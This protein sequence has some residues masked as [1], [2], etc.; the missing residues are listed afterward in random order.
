MIDIDFQVKEVKLLP[1]LGE[2]VSWVFVKQTDGTLKT[3]PVIKHEGDVLHKEED[4]DSDEFE[5]DILEEMYDDP[6]ESPEIYETVESDPPPLENGTEIGEMDLLRNILNHV[7][8][9]GLKLIEDDSEVALGCL[10][11]F[12]DSIMNIGSFSELQRRL[13]FSN[14]SY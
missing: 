10:R 12:N 4:L 11:N 7:E 14:G 5:V 8:I 2:G 6:I 1:N 3:V 13:E 9:L